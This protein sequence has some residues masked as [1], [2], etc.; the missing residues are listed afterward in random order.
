MSIEKSDNFNPGDTVETKE[1][2]QD[3]EYIPAGTK[4]V[5][6]RKNGEIMWYG[7]GYIDGRKRSLLILTRN[8]RLIKKADTSLSA[9]LQSK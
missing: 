3:F 4:I 2:E 6:A 7:E 5:L 8:L 9:P 1:G